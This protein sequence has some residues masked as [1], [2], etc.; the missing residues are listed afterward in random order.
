M[1]FPRT[2]KNGG[3]AASCTPSEIG[4]AGSDR[5]C[6]GGLVVLKFR[7]NGAWVATQRP[8]AFSLVSLQMP[9]ARRRRR[10]VHY[11]YRWRA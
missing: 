8:Q 6:D 11:R 7:R 5:R 1:S 9:T 2:R 3:A 4:L 10:Q